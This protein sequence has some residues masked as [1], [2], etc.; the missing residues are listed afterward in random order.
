ATSKARS[1]IDH[2]VDSSVDGLT[3]SAMKGAK[4]ARSKLIKGSMITDF[5]KF[6]SAWE[7]HADDPAQSVF[8]LVIAALNYSV[9]DKVLGDA[10][11]TIPLAKTHNEKVEF[12]P[13]GLKLGPSNRK[14]FQYMRNDPNIAKSYLGADYT[15]DYAFNAKKLEMKVL[16]T[17]IDSGQASVIIQSGGK[18]NPTPIKLAENKNG[19]WKVIEFSSLATG[20]RKPS[21][22]AGDF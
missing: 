10:M 4:S 8:Y 6:K 3:A 13:S 7:K 21:S 16:A 22:V 9:D 2:K 14:L 1:S 11:A 20:V 17:V 18:D 15:N 19:Q 5:K 12:T